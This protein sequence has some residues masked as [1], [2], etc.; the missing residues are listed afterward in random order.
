[1]NM[2]AVYEQLFKSSIHRYKQKYSSASKEAQTKAQATEAQ[3]IQ[4]GI[5]VVRQK[6]RFLLQHLA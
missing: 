6:V 3:H 4:G 1:M 2:S 5:F